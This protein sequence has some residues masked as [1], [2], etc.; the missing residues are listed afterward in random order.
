MLV[1]CPPCTT[2]LEPDAKR[3]SRRRLI[4]LLW[5]RWRWRRMRHGGCRAVQWEM[6]RAGLLRVIGPSDSWMTLVQRETQ[7]TGAS[8]WELCLGLAPDW[9]LDWPE[10]CRA[11]RPSC[12]VARRILESGAWPTGQCGLET[13]DGSR[14]HVT[15][16]RLGLPLC[17]PAQPA[18]VCADGWGGNGGGRHSSL[19]APSP[20]SPAPLRLPNGDWLTARLAHFLP[21][22][23]LRS[24]SPQIASYQQVVSFLPSA[25]GSQVPV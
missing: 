10:R 6:S 1:N 17:R 3:S 20:H 11:T 22:S 12:K 8:V 4:A 5:Q 18:S 7:D 14:V 24:Q 19:P 2:K 9:R 15:A 13:R 23:S 21:S 25:R 16:G